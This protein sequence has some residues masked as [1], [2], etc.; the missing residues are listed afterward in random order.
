VWFDSL[1]ELMNRKT[2]LTRGTT[3]SPASLGSVD[4]KTNSFKLTPC[5]D[6]IAPKLK[7]KMKT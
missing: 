7:C 1:L 5:R 3:R 6:R 2:E 4:A